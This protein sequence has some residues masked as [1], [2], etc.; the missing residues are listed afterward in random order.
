MFNKP[1]NR[2]KRR[3]DK[4]GSS[5][6]VIIKFERTCYLYIRLVSALMV[7]RAMRAHFLHS[8]IVLSNIDTNPIGLSKFSRFRNMSYV[9]INQGKTTFY[10][11]LKHN[12]SNN[13]L[14]SKK[15]KNMFFVSFFCESNF[16]TVIYKQLLLTILDCKFELVFFR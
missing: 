10:W 12:L 14:K 11:Q 6:F 3:S 7:T 1:V 2:D 16:P 5:N 4:N 8:R 15:I 9:E 13:N